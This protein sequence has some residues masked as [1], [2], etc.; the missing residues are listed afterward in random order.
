M[1]H[2]QGCGACWRRASKLLCTVGDKRCESAVR[3]GT[4]ERVVVNEGAL[5][6]FSV[7]WQGMHGLWAHVACMYF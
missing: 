1:R 4:T 5:K 6:S 3:M 7:V 2:V